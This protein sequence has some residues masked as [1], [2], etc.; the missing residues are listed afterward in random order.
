MDLHALQPNLYGMEI[1]HVGG[2]CSNWF[3]KWYI[4]YQLWAAHANQHTRAHPDC[5]WPIE[6]P[7]VSAEINALSLYVQ[8]SMSDRTS[9]TRPGDI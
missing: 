1:A 7:A 5:E 8:V 4:L 6:A 9:S 3:R 2:S